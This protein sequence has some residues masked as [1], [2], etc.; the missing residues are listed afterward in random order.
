L[1]LERYQEHFARNQRSQSLDL[2]IGGQDD[3]GQGR[4]YGV[5][6]LIAEYEKALSRPPEP[7]PQPEPEVETE[8]RLKSGFGSGDGKAHRSAAEASPIL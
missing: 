4:Q 2:I 6:A 7:E 1:D 5:F 3:H 8:E